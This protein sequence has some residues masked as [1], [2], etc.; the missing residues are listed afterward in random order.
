M[1]QSLHHSVRFYKFVETGANE[2]R[3]DQEI[4]PTWAEY[5]AARDPV[6]EWVL[7]YPAK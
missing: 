3:P 6:L 4:I 2:I 5:K 7:K 1:R